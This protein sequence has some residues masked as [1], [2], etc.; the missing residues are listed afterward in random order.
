MLHTTAELFSNDLN[1]CDFWELFSE[2]QW[3]NDRFFESN[4][5]EQLLGDLRCDWYYS[6]I[7]LYFKKE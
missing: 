4:I 6:N 2:I 7:M 3:R 5:L 1:T